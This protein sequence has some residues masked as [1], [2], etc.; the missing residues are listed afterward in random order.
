LLP[1]NTIVKIV[2]MPPASTSQRSTGNAET[3]KRLPSWLFYLPAAVKNL[4]RDPDGSS[5]R[6]LL[7]P[8]LRLKTKSP[9]RA[10][11]PPR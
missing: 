11:V 3:P 4:E 7:L 2:R 6:I 9:E 1:Y 5:S 10:F 8:V